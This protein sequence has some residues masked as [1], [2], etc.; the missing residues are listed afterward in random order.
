MSGPGPGKQTCYE[1]FDLEVKP[2]LSLNFFLSFLFFILWKYDDTFIGDL[3]Q[4]KVTY[5]STI[6][7][8][9]LSG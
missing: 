4:S 1:V 6:Y 3:E 2:W 9:Y 7:D 8:N 5:S